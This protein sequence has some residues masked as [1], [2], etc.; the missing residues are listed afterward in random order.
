MGKP[1]A[2]ILRLTLPRDA[3]SMN[4]IHCLPTVEQL[5]EH[6]HH[7]LCK[8][9]L[10]DPKQTP[11]AHSVIV[12]RGKPCGLFVQ[13]KGPRLLKNYAIWAGNEN[14]IFLYTASGER[15]GEIKLSEA[16]DLSCLRV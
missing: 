9:D 8:K 11:L 16:P 7:A 3:T 5:L 12:R 4:Q 2:V 13:V 14:R 15:F 6:V 1:S 10:L